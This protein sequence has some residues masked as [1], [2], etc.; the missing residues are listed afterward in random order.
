MKICHLCE[1]KK[2][3]PSEKQQ[4][5]RPIKYIVCPACRGT[6]QAPE[7]I[8]TKRSRVTIIKA[9]GIYMSDEVWEKNSRTVI[10]ENIGAWR[11]LA[12]D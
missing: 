2:K 5:Q 3:I 11:E 12:N 4:P 6:G 9:H 10:D 1:G 7:E 8:K